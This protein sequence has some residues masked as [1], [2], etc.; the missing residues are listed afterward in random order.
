[1]RNG[2]CSFPCP[3]ARKQD[4]YAESAQTQVM[5]NGHA[6]SLSGPKER[7]EI[8]R[9]VEIIDRK[10]ASEDWRPYSSKKEWIKLKSSTKEPETSSKTY[11]PVSN[12]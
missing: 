5:V 4:L 9:A 12:G 2:F 11:S 8:Q 6:I 10:V 7:A 3:M 1:M